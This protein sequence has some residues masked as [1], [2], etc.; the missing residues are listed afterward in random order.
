M[1]GACQ[2]FAKKTFQQKNTRGRRGVS[3]IA[4]RQVPRN[5][6]M[7]QIRGERGFFLARSCFFIYY[8]SMSV[9]I[10]PQTSFLFTRTGH[11]PDRKLTQD[12]ETSRRGVCAERVQGPEG[13]SVLDRKSTRL[14]SRHQISS[15]T[16]FC[17][18]K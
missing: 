11:V 14:N 10:L 4:L 2:T 9:R 18:K 16:V 3:P 1:H 6:G 15:Y 7:P 5:Q 17:L 8:G 12:T 13:C